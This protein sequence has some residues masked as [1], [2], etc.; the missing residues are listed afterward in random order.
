MK[1]IEV[2]MRV[3][4]LVS[5]TSLVFPASVAHGV[6]VSKTF[7]ILYRNEDVN[8]DDVILFKTHVLVD[9]LKVSWAMMWYM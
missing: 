8:I 3:N 4:Q 1:S 7:Q 9:A 6:G 2:G 5:G